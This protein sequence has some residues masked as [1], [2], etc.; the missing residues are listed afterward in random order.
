MGESIK[1]IGKV[2]AVY[3]TKDWYAGRGCR[4][5]RLACELY[6]V[7]ILEHSFLEDKKETNVREI[8]IHDFVTLEYGQPKEMTIGGKHVDL[9]ER[10]VDYE[11]TK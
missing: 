2:D 4:I 8:D 5:E 11:N 1:F 6:G 7:K 10:R 3:F 9:I